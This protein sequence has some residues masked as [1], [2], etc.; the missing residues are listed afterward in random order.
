MNKNKVGVVVLNWNK[1]DDTIECLRSLKKTNYPYY[2]IIV[3]DNASED[4]SAQTIKKL[5]PEAYVLENQ[6]N[7]GYAGGNNIGIQHALKDNAKYI[8]MLNNDTVVAPDAMEKL[9]AQADSMPKAGMFSPCIND[10]SIPEKT[11]YCG[12]FFDK[13]N[14]KVINFK[15]LNDL[16]AA[17]ENDICLW[18]T[19]LF[20]K[21]EIIRKI[22]YLNERF[23][24]YNEDIEYSMR[25]S[26]AGYLNRMV[27]EAKVYHK[28]SY[29]ESPEAAHLPEYYFYYMTR[30][31][32][33]LWNAYTSTRNKPVFLSKYLARTLR[34]IGF[35]KK[36]RN[37]ERVDAYLD[38]LYCAFRNRG[39]RR[40]KKLKTPRI[41]KNF[42]LWH[43]YLL[44]DLIEFNFKQIFNEALK[45]TSNT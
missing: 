31:E 34:H 2:E 11:Q 21:A 41:L 26:R 3:V 35:Y 32:L 17:N 38:G 5:F 29:V 7:L 39:G 20:V 30:N 28:N 23:Y 9:V 15:G 27:P 18:G 12:S 10:Y 16:K 33:W 37:T 42:I 19:A 14:Y 45:R 25:V 43:P 44:S 6:E 4:G 22:G 8:W 36:T 13:I 40:D 1:C 24:L